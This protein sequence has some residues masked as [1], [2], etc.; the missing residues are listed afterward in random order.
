[1]NEAGEDRIRV[2]IVGDSAIKRAGLEAALADAGRFE[3]VGSTTSAEVQS[4]VAP[5]NQ[6][7]PRRTTTGVDAARAAMVLAVMVFT[8]Q[9]LRL[10]LQADRSGASSGLA[11]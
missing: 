11:Q 3:V 10:F 8:L 6:G 2:L 4:L 5:A 1:M 7:N 9:R